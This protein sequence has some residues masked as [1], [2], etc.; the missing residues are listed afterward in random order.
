MRRR[1][2]P[3]AQLIFV[4]AAVVFVGDLS[5]IQ[6]GTIGGIA[7]ESGAEYPLAFLGML[8]AQTRNA[9]V[10]VTILVGL[11]TIV[12]LLAKSLSKT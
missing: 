6:W 7:T 4:I 11:G 9:L 8:F 10:M 2:H 5:T 3:I 1:T 12:D